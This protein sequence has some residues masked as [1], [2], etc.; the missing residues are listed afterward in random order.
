MTTSATIELETRVRALVQEFRQD[1]WC[2]SYAE[3]VGV[4]ELVKADLAREA[5]EQRDEEEPD[6]HGE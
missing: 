1:G 5:L 3:T 6:C 2:I 4:L